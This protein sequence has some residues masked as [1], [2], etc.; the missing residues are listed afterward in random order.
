MSELLFPSQAWFDEYRERIDDD[1]E[2][3]D[4]AADWGVGFDGDIVFEMTDMPVDELDHDA[5]PEEQREEID[6][7]VDEETGTGHALLGL[8]AGECTR[9]TFVEDLDD[10]A[11][12][13]VMT[14]TNDVWK[15]LVSGEI[16]AIDG[17]MSGKFEIRGDMQKMLEYSDAA[18]RLTEISAGIDAEFV[19]EEYA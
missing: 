6:R 15:E 19:D 14:A 4:L 9:A 3:A 2:Y 1:E 7:Y 11:Y 8:E 12:G 13:F 18:A 10:E 17:M 16:G 5:L